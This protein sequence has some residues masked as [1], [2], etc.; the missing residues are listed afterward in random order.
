MKTFFLIV[1]FC[2]LA[3]IFTALVVMVATHALERRRMRMRENRAVRLG[4]ERLLKDIEV[5]EP[6][7]R[8]QM[9]ELDDFMVFEDLAE[10]PE[11]VKAGIEWAEMHAAWKQKP[12][13]ELFAA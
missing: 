6:L 8:E 11:W 7:T 5:A 2:W 1:L 13:D 3:L 12:D 10:D 4:H 9:D